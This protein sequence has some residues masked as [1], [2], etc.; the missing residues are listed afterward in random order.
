MLWDE[1]Y[2]MEIFPKHPKATKINIYLRGSVQASMVKLSS[3]WYLGIMLRR[4]PPLLILV[5]VMTVS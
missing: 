3:A 2:A 5:A 1:G 4:D